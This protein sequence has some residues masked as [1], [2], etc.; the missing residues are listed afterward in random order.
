MECECESVVRDVVKGFSEI[1]DNSVVLFTVRSVCM[2]GV[3]GFDD[4]LT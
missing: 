1:K 4:V 2:S 3:I